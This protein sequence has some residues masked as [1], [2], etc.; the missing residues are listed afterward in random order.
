MQALS[1][2]GTPLALRMRPW[3]DQTWLLA[4]LSDTGMFCVTVARSAFPTSLDLPYLMQTCSNTSVSTH[5][6]RAIAT[7]DKRR[8]VITLRN[9]P[10][11]QDPS[12]GVLVNDATPI[13]MIQPLSDVSFAGKLSL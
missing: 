1:G 8:V 6:G 2:L 9:T 4:V 3:L 11:K 12:R 5:R 10:L 13:C 7:L